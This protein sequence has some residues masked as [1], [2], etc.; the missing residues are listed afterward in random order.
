MEIAVVIPVYKQPQYLIESVDSVMAQR[1]VTARALIVDDGC[2]Y[3]STHEIGLALAH[4]FPGR[5]YYLRR[6]NGGLSAARN[7]GIDV[8]LAMWP[9]LDAVFPLDADNRLSQDTLA[10]LASVLDLHPEA[11]WASPNLETFG[12]EHFVWEPASP[13]SAYR[14]LFDNQCDA[15]SLI[16]RE[17]FASGLRYDE[18]MRHGYEDWEFYLRAGARGFRG[19][20][21]GACGFRYRRKAESLL[22]TAIDRREQIL[23]HMR[24]SNPASFH[25]R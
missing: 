21:A 24:T 2:P 14:Q 25:P 5:A 18:G 23:E 4:A 17:V 20:Q 19:I 12:N 9:D 11:A 16:R 22:T 7:T 3:E 1:G 10:R 8:A 15:G 13:Y 6:P